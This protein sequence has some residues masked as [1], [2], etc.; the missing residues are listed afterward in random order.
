VLTA[1]FDETNRHGGIFGRRIEPR[2]LELPAEPDRRPEAI[3][4]FVKDQEVFALVASFLAGTDDVSA[5]FW[6]DLQVPVAGALSHAL[7]TGDARN[8]YVFYLDG[9]LDGQVK[10]LVDL[11]MK[12]WSASK[13][14]FGAVY[15]PENQ[16]RANTVVEGLR[17]IG[18]TN[19]AAFASGKTTVGTGIVLV[20][21][22]VSF[23][24]G[25][26]KRILLVPGSLLSPELMKPGAVAGG[27]LF[28]AFPMVPSDA[29][30]EGLAEY[31][32]LADTYHLDPGLQALQFSA[33]T[34]AKLFIEALTRAG[35]DLTRE[36][37]IEILQNIQGFQ[38][39]FAPPLSFGVTRR[40]GLQAH[41]L[42][43]NGTTKQCTAFKM[44]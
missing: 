20:L 21:G 24:S 1:W 15:S 44:K 37:V 7:H 16:D 12:N 29:T 26:G 9:G 5:S 25:P 39:G 19:A 40:E 43:I 3:R 28:T 2:F 34:S 11:A 41:V 33:I 8:R 31:K 30:A 42:E 18:W 17:A 32:H 4:A 22:A 38:T 13:P 23:D 14:D 36:R 35:R 10:A 6:Q 27:R